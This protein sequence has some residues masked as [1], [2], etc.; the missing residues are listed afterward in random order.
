MLRVHGKRSAPAADVTEALQI[1]RL[2]RRRVAQVYPIG[3]PATTPRG[4]LVRRYGPD[5]RL[6][7][8]EPCSYR[9]TSALVTTYGEGRMPGAAEDLRPGG[10]PKVACQS[11]G[12]PRTAGRGLSPLGGE[13][14][15]KSTTPLP[16]RE[17]RKQ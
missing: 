9:R 1:L 7:A 16:Y 10:L 12:D 15:G 6:I 8:R 17:E 5:S 3:S 14:R 2:D 13:G 4:T 11:W